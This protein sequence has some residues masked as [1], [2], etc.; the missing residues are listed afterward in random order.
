MYVCTFASFPCLFSISWTA[1]A[2]CTYTVH[3][4]P[5]AGNLLAMPSGKLCYLDFGMVSY[6]EAPQR[7]NI[8]EAVVHIVNRDFDALTGLYKRMGFIPKEVDPAPIVNAL[9]DVLPDVLNA[10]VKEL[11]FKTVI[12]KL[13]DIMFKFPFSLPPF[14][15]AIIRCLG[16]LEGLAIQVDDEFRIIDDAY[17]YIASRLLTDPS[18]ELQD[19]LRQLLFKD[20][21]PNYERLL[22]L[23]ERASDTSDYDVSM[24][25]DQL[26]GYLLQPQARDIREELTMRLADIIDELGADALDFTTQ[27]LRSPT[28]RS[29]VQSLRRLV[30]TL[31]Q[32]RTQGVPAIANLVTQA[33]IESNVQPTESLQNAAKLVS[34][35]GKQG[36]NNTMYES[37][38]Y[39]YATTPTPVAADA[40]INY[41]KVVA[42]LRKVLREPAAQEMIATVVSE[43]SDRAAARLVNRMLRQ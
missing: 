29:P 42:V 10:P 17:P 1:L 23:L 30:G 25:I 33:S 37:D 9:E 27:L 34:L 19:A 7:L 36:R 38:S 31:R 3:A 8:I 14:Y 5:H 15:I 32:S 39:E 24:A 2:S 6:V 40:N 12:S 16:V 4:D 18:E 22:E 26:M 28:S 41:E 13:G 35:I 43:V 21:R 11:N 20:N